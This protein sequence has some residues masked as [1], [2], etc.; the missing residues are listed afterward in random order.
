MHSEHTL[1]HLK[2]FINEYDKKVYDK[3]KF[4]IESLNS[5][6]VIKIKPYNSLQN[7]SD[8][9]NKIIMTFH[10]I[11]DHDFKTNLEINAKIT[12]QVSGNDVATNDELKFNIDSIKLKD[13]KNCYVF[14]MNIYK[15][16]IGYG[17]H[18]PMC[19]SPCYTNGYFLLDCN[20]LCINVQVKDAS[21]ENE[22]KIKI[23][24]E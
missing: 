20:S 9:H 2:S 6:D 24:I 15:M 14:T 21:H 23:T 8:V 18:L 12:V 3:N 11:H 13:I 17:M 1:N 10:D 22:I 7:L 19:Y 4:D 5:S 16:M